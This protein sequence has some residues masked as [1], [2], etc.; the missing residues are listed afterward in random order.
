MKK[1][2]MLKRL[3]MLYVSLLP[4]LSGFTQE[5]TNLLNPALPKRDSLPIIKSDSLL[6]DSLAYHKALIAM[7]HNDS[8]SKWPLNTGYPLAGAILPTHRIVAYYGNFYS[9]K[10]GVLGEYPKAQVLGK[11]KQE[12]LRWQAADTTIPVIPA[13]HYI[14]VTAQGSPGNGNKYRLRMPFTEIDKVVNMAKEIDALVFIDVQ[15]GQSSVEAELPLLEK[16]L[17]MPNVHFGI[18]PEFSMKAGQVPGSIIGSIDAAAINYASEWL[19]KLVTQYH[20]PPKILVI[21]RFTRKMVTNYQQ[22]KLHPEIQVVMDMDGWGHQARKINTYQ[23]FI[24]REPVQFTGFKLF[25]K[26]D[27]GEAK[28]HLMQPAEVLKLNPKP[29]YIQYQ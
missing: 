27:L 26:N 17:K 24:K 12:I 1:T 18:D 5:N 3:L 21:H 28:S 7:L 13:L 2:K 6:L 16:Y 4:G 11:L 9:K 14:A 10:M 29:V 25:Y 22:I 19:A 15:L 20:L 23:T 8:L